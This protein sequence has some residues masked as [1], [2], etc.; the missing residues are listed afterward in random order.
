MSRRDRAGGVLALATTLKLLLSLP[1]G[2]RM[3]LIPKDLTVMLVTQAAYGAQWT[4]MHHSITVNIARLTSVKVVSP[5]E[6]WCDRT[7]QRR[8]VFSCVLSS[9]LVSI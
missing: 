1:L 3:L 4:R 8:P 7:N 5:S 6:N 2:K 9:I